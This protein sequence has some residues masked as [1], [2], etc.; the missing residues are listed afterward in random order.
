MDQL[1]RS[2][3]G[4]FKSQLAIKETAISKLCWVTWPTVKIL[5]KKMTHISTL[6][7]FELFKS[8]M[9]LAAAQAKQW[10]KKKNLQVNYIHTG[11]ISTYGIN[12]L[13]TQIYLDC[14]DHNKIQ[15]HISHLV[16]H[17]K[18]YIITYCVLLG[19][20]RAINVWVS[21]GLVILVKDIFLCTWMSP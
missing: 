21:T 2:I 20:E 1:K 8:H 5:C 13:C 16:V 15:S 4:N 12:P 6:R 17:M 7:R 3:T 18:K 11:Q 9:L 19:K 14:S 10:L